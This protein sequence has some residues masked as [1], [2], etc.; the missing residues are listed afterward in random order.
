LSITTETVLSC[1]AEK[2]SAKLD[3][4][5]TSAAVGNSVEVAALA[6]QNKYPADDRF[7]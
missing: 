6:T 3:D 1:A 7:A 4:P 5:K 2:S